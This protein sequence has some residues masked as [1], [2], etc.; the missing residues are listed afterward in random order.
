MH[1]HRGALMHSRLGRRTHAHMKRLHPTSSRLSLSHTHEEAPPHLL[2]PLTHTHTLGGSTRPPLPSR[3]GRRAAQQSDETG[4]S[5][6]AVSP[7]LRDRR[8]SPAVPACACVSERA[9]VCVGERLCEG[10][11]SFVTTTQSTDTP[12]HVCHVGLVCLDQ[13]AEFLFI[14]CRFTAYLSNED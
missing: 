10:K 6:G 1:F 4:G 8:G 5:L 11:E 14:S 7:C 2:S 9:C 13:F 12:G 3:I